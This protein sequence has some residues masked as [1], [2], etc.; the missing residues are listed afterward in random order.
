MKRQQQR[1]RNTVKNKKKSGTKNQKPKKK[2]K[3]RKLAEKTQKQSKSTNKEK[4]K[5]IKKAR[6]G[7]RKKTDSRVNTPRVNLKVTRGSCEN[8]T[9]LNNLMQVMKINKDTV[10]NFL[11]Q[12]NRTDSKIKIAVSKGKKSGKTNESLALLGKSLG[13]EPAIS[14]SSPVCG[15]RYN[16]TVANTVG[17]ATATYT[18][19]LFPVTFDLRRS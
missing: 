17:P 7:R 3:K 11:Q 13:G 5:K 4:F 9:C 6:K 16:S 10:Q 14:K 12:K 8:I 2:K 18:V 15:G 1:R 19:S